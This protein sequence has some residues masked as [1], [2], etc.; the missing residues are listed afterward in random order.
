MTCAEVR[1]HAAELV[2]G[3]LDGETRALVVGHLAS[4]ASCRAE[5]A[6]L[7]RVTDAL[8]LTAPEAEPPA[9]FESRVL[10]AV[11]P[12]R[13]LWSPRLLA[14]AA[15]V[16]V[17]AAAFVVVARP[18]GAPEA[19]GAM[20]DRSRTAVGHA[21]VHGGS[22]SYVYVTLDHWGDG[23]DYVVEVIRKDGSHVVVTPIH[24]TGGRGSAGGPLPVAFGDVKAV[25]VTDRA[26]TE[27]CAFKV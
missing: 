7:T 12:R 2:L 4:C 5:V 20:L 23:G 21:V 18:S 22:P 8:W 25:W 3:T 26:H 1:E 19:A 24:L 10:R 27:W 6:D 16:L 13:R 17:F 9:G 14:T 11:R 15:A